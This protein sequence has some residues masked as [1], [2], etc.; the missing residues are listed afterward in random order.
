MVR[1]G[2]ERNVYRVFMGKPEGKKPL[3]RPRRRWDDGIRMDLREI[4]WG[5]GG[6]VD[7][8]QLAQDRD[9]WRAVVNTVM[10]LRVLAP[11]SYLVIEVPLLCV[12]LNLDQTFIYKHTRTLF[13]IVL[14]LIEM[15]KIIH[16]SDKLPGFTFG[17]IQKATG[18]SQMTAV[19]HLHDYDKTIQWMCTT[20]KA[21]R[22]VKAS[23]LVPT[24]YD[25]TCICRAAISCANCPC[26][27]YEWCRF[28]CLVL[29]TTIVILARERLCSKCD[30]V[31]NLFNKSCWRT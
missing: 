6:G 2:E 20:M 4:G 26:R 27:F 14:H 8:I 22:L 30:K 10:N 19:C 5:G 25:V 16:V 23:I 15:V 9:R 12:C 28:T 11:R 3:G 31:F 1:M 17:A 29:T 18:S 7:W 21:L 13:S 24:K